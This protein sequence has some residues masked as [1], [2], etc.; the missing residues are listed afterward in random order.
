MSTTYL[1]EKLPHL[2]Q[3]K[4]FFKPTFSPDRYHVAIENRF[5]VFVR[6]DKKEDFIKICFDADVNKNETIQTIN[7][8]TYFITLPILQ[9]SFNDE[10]D[11]FPTADE[12]DIAKYSL[13]KCRFCQ[14][15][16]YNLSSR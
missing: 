8:N 14:N 6:K 2:K 1:L 11:D 3:Y 9:D 4:L 10:T 13:I 12:L 7:D 16:I 5:I 15:I